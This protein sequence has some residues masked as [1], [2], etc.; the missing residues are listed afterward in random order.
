VAAGV[1]V[2]LLPALA[3]LPGFGSTLNGS[4][5][6]R[7]FAPPVPTRTIAMVWR[8][9]YARAATIRTV[10]E[11]IRTNMSSQGGEWCCQP[12]GTSEELRSTA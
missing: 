1:G 10:A 11:V 3:T 9:S 6:V 12:E 5:Q 2:A 4:V 7:P 8:R